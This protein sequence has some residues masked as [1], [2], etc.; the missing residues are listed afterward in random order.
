M[1]LFRAGA[2]QAGGSLAQPSRVAGDEQDAGSVGGKG[3][4]GGEADALTGACDQRAFSEKFHCATGLR[5]GRGSLRSLGRA[6]FDLTLR[7]RHGSH[8]L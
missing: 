1:P 3:L 4:G 2:G 5:Y 6:R 7:I 8:N